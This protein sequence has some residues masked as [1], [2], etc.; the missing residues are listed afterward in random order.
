MARLRPLGRI[1]ISAIRNVADIFTD[2]RTAGAAVHVYFHISVALTSKHARAGPQWVGMGE[3]WGCV[4][5]SN[6]Y[7]WVS[8]LQP[9]VNPHLSGKT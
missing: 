7:L 4:G 3:L 9:T 5:W 6:T 2:Y 1:F 8:P